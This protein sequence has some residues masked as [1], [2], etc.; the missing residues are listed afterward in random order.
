MRFKISAIDQSVLDS[1]KNVVSIRAVSNSFSKFKGGPF[2]GFSQTSNLKPGIELISPSPNSKLN[3]F[4]ST[5]V[6]W[7]SKNIESVSI[8][9]STDSGKTWKEIVKNYSGN[10]YKYSWIVPATPTLN[11]YLKISSSED[12][13]IK[14]IDGKFQISNGFVKLSSDTLFNGGINTIVPISWLQSGVSRVN[15]LSRSNTAGSNWTKVVSNYDASAGTYLWIQKQTLSGRHALKIENV[16]GLAIRDSI[17]I[18]FNPVSA[19]PTVTKYRGGSYDGH[20]SRSNISKIL[21]SKPQSG[22]VLIAG[23]TYNITWS[24]VNVSDSV[25]IEYSID[26]GQTWKVISVAVDSKTGSYQWTVP[27]NTVGPT[28]SFKKSGNYISAALD[29]CKIRISETGSQNE[30]VG[31]SNKT[32]IISGSNDTRKLAQQTIT[33][34]PI[35]DKSLG[36]AAFELEASASSGLPVSFSVV[37]GAATIL[38]NTITLTG[39]GMV[40]VIASQGGNAGFMAAEAVREFKINEL[41]VTNFSIRTVGESCKTSNNGKIEIKA[42]KILNYTAT[43]NGNGLSKVISFKDILEIKDLSAGNYSL[44]VTVEG[45][46]NY[47]QCY[48][49]VITEPIDLKVYASSTLKDLNLILAGGDLYYI[50]FNG[51]NYTTSDKHF[52][53]PLRKGVNQVRVSTDGQC[54]G[55]FTKTII[56]DENVL[57]YPNPFENALNLNLPSGSKVSKIIILD[58]AGK[59]VYTGTNS[60]LSTL[61]EI[62][63]S[64]LISGAYILKLSSANSETIHKILKK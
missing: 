49:L 17:N 42:T 62:D 35:S 6:T 2:D 11:G 32:F 3:G 14:S 20:S 31:L 48:D 1:S 53:I 59:I 44:C 23:T 60:G 40:K 12:S 63:L 64:T 34:E 9:F 7:K 45:Q 13:T 41:P 52:T 10:A 18:N 46:D 38:E 36:D 29:E 37:Y 39:T 58:I 4:A 61:L 51:E 50:N 43:I 5:Q 19:S 21:I 26:N 30:V 15:I 27:T 22:E 8:H 33:F 54:Q 47:K 28:S 56:V 25:K 55:I 16:N 24:T 57:V